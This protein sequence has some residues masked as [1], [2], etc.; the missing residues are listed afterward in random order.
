M[1]TL[2]PIGTNVLAMALCAMVVGAVAAAPEPRTEPAADVDGLVA[3]AR[4][5]L[6]RGDTDRA[7]SL[8]TRAVDA[9][10]GKPVGYAMRALVYEARRDFEKCVPDYTKVLSLLPDNIPALH[11]RGEAYFRLGRFRES[12]ADFDKEVS[13]DASREPYHWQ[14]GI[15]LYYAGEFA[16]GARQFELHRT[17]NGDDVENAAWHYLCVARQSGVEKARQSLL[18][19][20]PDPRVPLPQIYELFAGKL[21]P[22]AVIQAAKA[23]DPPPDQLKQHLFYA[24][25]YIGLYLDAAGAADKSREH[26]RL[27]AEKYAEDDY[28]GDVARI[29]AARMKQLDHR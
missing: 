12:V 19:V 2:R 24:H 25:L 10:P 1:R 26:I 9:A 6:A 17:V 4:S 8:S 21:K 7:L 16:R 11:R 23:K 27:A 13:L 15:S 29:H 14:R 3:Q 28:M 5:A 20:G 22:E 18:P